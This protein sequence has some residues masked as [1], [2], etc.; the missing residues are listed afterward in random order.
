MAPKKLVISATC[1]ILPD[2]NKEVHK[3][4]VKKRRFWT[5]YFLTTRSSLNL[6][7]DIIIEDRSGLFRYFSRMSKPDFNFLVSK[8]SEK[9]GKRDTNYR[10]CIPVDIRLAITLRFLATGDSYAGLMYLFR[11]SK[12]IIAVIIPEVCLASY[13]LIL[14]K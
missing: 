14:L 11:V 5:P 8:V 4:E 12:Q 3:K 13:F 6:L 2:L 9:V 1:L 10:T 7:N